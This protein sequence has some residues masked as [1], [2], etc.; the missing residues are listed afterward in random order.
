MAAPLGY[1]AIAWE[2]FYGLWTP[3]GGSADI[4]AVNVYLVRHPPLRGDNQDERAAS[5]R[6]RMRW[7]R[8]D[9]VRA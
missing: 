5:I 1:A 8:T 7:V 4:T 6:M 3:F 2:D 9:G